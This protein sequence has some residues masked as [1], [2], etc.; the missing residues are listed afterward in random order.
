[1]SGQNS[2]A[3][4]AIAAAT[5]DYLREQVPHSQFN[6]HSFRRYRCSFDSTLRYAKRMTIRLWRTQSP[7]CT[8]ISPVPMLDFGRAKQDCFGIGIQRSARS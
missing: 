5:V 3:T 2:L 8:Q 6:G 1:M 4:N 7:T